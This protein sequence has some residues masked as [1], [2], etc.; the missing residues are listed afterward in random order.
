MEKEG[1][2]K[3]FKLGKEK[4]IEDD[5]IEPGELQE[6]EIEIRGGDSRLTKG[7]TRSN[8]SASERAKLDAYRKKKR[9][10]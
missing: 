5:E 4:D 10:G 9:G 8:L 2:K 6:S 3:F 1:Y 7:I